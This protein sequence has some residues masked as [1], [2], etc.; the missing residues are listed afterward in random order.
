[1][2]HD[3]LFLPLYIALLNFKTKCRLLPPNKVRNDGKLLSWLGRFASV[4][5]P[6]PPELLYRPL[7]AQPSVQPPTLPRPYPTP[8]W[9]PPPTPPY[10]TPCPASILPTPLR[11]WSI[12]PVY[13]TGFPY[14]SPSA[15]PPACLVLTAA[16]GGAV[17]SCA[18][19]RLPA[20]PGLPAPISG[21]TDPG[22]S[23]CT[24]TTRR[25]QPNKR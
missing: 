4:T 21:H 8:N 2:F 11:W 20:R 24:T 1:M 19:G 7:A 10:L 17:R 18:A 23:S 13:S 12:A 6:R 9:A 15:A 16:R 14:L 3:N 25:A 5:Y 22:H